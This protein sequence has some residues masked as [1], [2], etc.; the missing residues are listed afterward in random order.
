M[1]RSSAFKRILFPKRLKGS[2]KKIG[3]GGGGG[4]GGG[5]KG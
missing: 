2:G 4:G 3:V 5:K 1:D